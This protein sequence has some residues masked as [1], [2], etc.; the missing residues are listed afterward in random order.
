MTGTVSHPEEFPQ[1]VHKD[2]AVNLLLESTGRVS[3]NDLALDIM[4]ST[5]MYVLKYR[6]KYFGI[7]LGM[8]LP[9]IT[10]GNWLP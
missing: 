5:V 6:D 2:V 8:S 1:I 10:L 7:G 3:G 9:D 4:K